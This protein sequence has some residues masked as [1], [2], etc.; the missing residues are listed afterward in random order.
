[1]G[2]EAPDPTGTDSADD[3]TDDSSRLGST[4]RRG[5]LIGITTGTGL[6]LGAAAAARGPPDHAGNDDGV[7]GGGRG[8]APAGN[9]DKPGRGPP[10][11]VIVGTKTQAA[12]DEAAKQ[13]REVRH[14][15]D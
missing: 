15:L 2:T 6:G 9:D 1:M 3:S 4:T 14:K 10:D 7:D 5:V 11:Q 13:A 12:A 8:R